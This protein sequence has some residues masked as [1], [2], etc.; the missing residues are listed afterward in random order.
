MP[1]ARTR[2][3]VMV[4]QRANQAYQRKHKPDYLIILFAILL[5]SVGIILIYS[6]SPGLAVTRNVS[7]SF[8]VTKQMLAI[9]IGLL[10]F[11]MAAVVPLKVIMKYHKFLLAFALLM[12]IIALVQPVTETYQAHRWVRLGGLSVQSVEVA[13]LAL[14]ISLP[15]FLVERVRAG[16]INNYQ[17][18]LKPLLILLA[19]VG[20]VIAGLQSDLGSAFVLLVMG[21][22]IALVAGINLRYLLVLA[23]IAGVGIL[24]A[25]STSQYR[26]ERFFSFLNPGQNC[27]STSYQACQALVTVGSGG[28]FGQGIARGAQA[29]GYLPEA[30]NDSI[31]A[32]HA[33]KF[34]FIGS[35]VLVLIF[36]AL[37]TRIKIV[38][39]RA[40]D[41]FSRLIVVGVL[42]WISTQALI[43]IGAMIGVL[44]LK[45]IT[46]PLVSYGGTSMMFILAALGLV[47]NISHYTTYAVNEELNK[48]IHED[49]TSRGRNGRSHHAVARRRS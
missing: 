41:M 49:T 46:L 31:F 16:T 29:Y 2:R 19:A 13:K 9:G 34:G 40:P 1:Y 10:T 3:P 45:G 12:T 35:T 28:M 38:L 23:A 43:N 42:A 8:Y 20:V 11:A 7:E 15:L 21:A 14:V 18:T 24:L 44:P 4:G 37:F 39:E 32:I 36:G 25:I 6:I 33:E 30:A 47:F 26:R 22:A 5:M 48:E 17:K 27:Q